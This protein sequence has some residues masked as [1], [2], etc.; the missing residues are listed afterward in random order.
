MILGEKN[1]VVLTYLK[2]EV[3]LGECMVLET[4]QIFL[5]SEYLVYFAQLY[6]IW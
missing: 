5:L 3:E 4:S 2:S 6:I 1:L